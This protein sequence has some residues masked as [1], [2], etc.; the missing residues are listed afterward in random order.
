MRVA[1]VV[2]GSYPAFRGSQVLVSHL[3]EGLAERGHGV[4]LVTYGAGSGAPFGPRARRIVRDV[5]LVGRLWRT[6][7]RQAIDVIHAHNYEAALAGLM[8]G[9]LTGRPLVYHGH[10]ALRDELPT[11]F[12]SAPVRALARRLGGLLDAH[13]PRRADFCIA[14]SDDLAETLRRAGVR[15]HVLA[16]ITPAAAPRDLGATPTP[17]ASSDVVCYA[18]NLD[19]YQNLAFLVRTFTRVRRRVAAARLLVLTHPEALAEGTRA[20]AEAPGIEFVAAAS[21]AEVRTRLEAADV[22]V[23][24]RTERSGFPMKLLSYMAAGKA[25]V[26]CAGSAKGLRDGITGRVVPDADERA[27]ADA[28]VE[29]LENAELRERLGAAA[30]RAAEDAGAF[31]RVLDRIESIYR[32]VVAAE[33]SPARALREARPA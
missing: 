7:R 20:R 4:H 12:R 26:A 13:V 28:V 31:A 17:R 33:T 14:V 15:P 9:R 3:A 16:C 25:I 29:L 6:V 11:Y 18:G 23:C 21:Y 27:F 8:V 10:N 22:A 1:L 19:G 32:M 30:R 2:A 24:P 5:L